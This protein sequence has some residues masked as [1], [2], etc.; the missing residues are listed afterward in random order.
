MLIVF[1]CDGVLVDSE[2]LLQRVDMEMLGELG[3]PITVEEI[4]REHLGHTV[5]DMVANVERHLGKPLPDGFLNRRDEHFAALLHSELHAVPGV[6]AALD[7]LDELGYA[8]CVASSGSHEKMRMTLGR[9]GMFERFA[10]RIFS[11]QDV[12][13]G[14]PW[15]ELFLHAGQRMSFPPHR[16][17]VVEDSPAGITAARRARM[18]SIGYVAQTP[19]DMLTEA[20]TTID[21]MSR[22]VE[23]ITE[24]LAHSATGSDCTP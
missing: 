4:Y 22:L 16:C 11:A 7:R 20:D 5:A 19:A 14:K 21:D 13:R 9:V 18:R 2:R 15:P 1:D 12:S 24:L 8:S 3:W 6:V 17:I 10:G 23:A